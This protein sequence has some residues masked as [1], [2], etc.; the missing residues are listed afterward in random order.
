ML[1][2]VKFQVIV[3]KKVSHLS[4]KLTPIKLKRLKIFFQFSIGKDAVHQLTT[5]SQDTKKS[6][7]EEKALLHSQFQW[8]R[9]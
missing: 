7:I 5:W 4:M 2:Q 1:P 3:N 9:I 6:K 8:L